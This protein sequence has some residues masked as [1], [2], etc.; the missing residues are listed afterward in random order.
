MCLQA[1]VDYDYFE[2]ATSIGS[3]TVIMN[4]DLGEPVH[5]RCAV[6][7]NCLFHPAGWEA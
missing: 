6:T 3:V 7:H 4:S 5:N 1:T 2:R